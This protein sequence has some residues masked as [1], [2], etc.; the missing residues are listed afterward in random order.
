MNGRRERRECNGFIA[1]AA[2]IRPSRA[3]LNLVVRRGLKSRR[4]ILLG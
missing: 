3:P 1:L 2:Q 4:C